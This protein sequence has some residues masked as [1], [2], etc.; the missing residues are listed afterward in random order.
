MNELKHSVEESFKEH[1]FAM[2]GVSVGLMSTFAA[3]F[4]GILG[5]VA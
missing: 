3:V 5:I 2:I 1:P 4:F